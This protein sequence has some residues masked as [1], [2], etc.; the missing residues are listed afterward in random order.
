MDVRRCP[1]VEA[2][3]RDS[4]R[5]S[6]LWRAR[7]S[8]DRIQLAG[9]HELLLIATGQCAHR[10]AGVTGAARRSCRR[11]PSCAHCRL[12]HAI[13]PCLRPRHAMR[14]FPRAGARAAR[15]RD[16]DLPARSQPRPDARAVRSRPRAGRRARAAT[17]ADPHPPHRPRRRSRRSCTIEGGIAYDHH[18]PLVAQRQSVRAEEHSA[19][20]AIRS[21][22]PAAG[23]RRAPRR[24]SPR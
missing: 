2:A 19:S 7:A 1:H 14:R 4:P 18:S 3:C 24:A 10:R 5:R 12:D 8:V 13:V 16:A 9:E 15:H 20:A 17:R 6:A 22:S 21:R 11:A 23:P